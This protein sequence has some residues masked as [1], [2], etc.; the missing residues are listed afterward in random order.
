MAIFS[1]LGSSLLHRYDT[2]NKYE[3]VSKS[4][5]WRPWWLFSLFLDLIWISY[6]LVQP[7]PDSY[8]STY[9]SSQLWSMWSIPHLR[10]LSGHVGVPI[11]AIKLR[12]TVMFWACNSIPFKHVFFFY[13][14]LEPHQITYHSNI[15]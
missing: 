5:K 14:L 1:W 15:Y 4:I 3:M 7:N 13:V 6:S 2:H 10:S 11:I 9:M 12:M 8:M